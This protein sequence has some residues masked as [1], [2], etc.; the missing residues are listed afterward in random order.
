[1]RTAVFF[2]PLAILSVAAIWTASVVATQDA[3]LRA[4]PAAIA[5]D[6]P[7][8]DSIFPPEIT[9]PTF[10][11][12]DASAAI[13]WR[14]DIGFA[15]GSPAIRVQSKGDPPDI[16]EIDIACISKTNEVPKLTPEQ[17]AAHTWRPDDATWKTIKSHS[18][19]GPATVSFTGLGTD[20]AGA[21]LSLGRVEIHTSK[22]PVGAP[23][24]YRDVPLMP[25]ETEKG[26]IKPLA[27]AAIPLIAWRLRDIA[28]PASRVVLEETAYVR[29]LPFVLERR[30]DHGHGCRWPAE[31]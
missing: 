14:I 12:H 3:P 28:Q 15:D 10:I 21:A 4:E 5:I 8:Q 13:G 25:S 7:S 16:G 29:Q 6:Y 9:P 17:A 2:F 18:L 26:V 11:W 24:F 27:Q 22:D 23:I 20:T 1:M 30:Q 31:R 19:N